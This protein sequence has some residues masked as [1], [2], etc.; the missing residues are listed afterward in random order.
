MKE[1]EIVLTYLNGC[2]GAAYPQRSFDEAELADPADYIRHRHGPDFDKFEKEIRDNGQI[3]YTRRGT[4]TYI[5]EF[6]E[7]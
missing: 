5:Y 3:V 2:A 4:V 1:Y 7:L 6:T